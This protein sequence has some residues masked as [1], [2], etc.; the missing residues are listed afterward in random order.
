MANLYNRQLSHW[1]TW[2]W[3]TVIII[4]DTRR[5]HLKPALHLLWST[6]VWITCVWLC[7][8]MVLL[9]K[10]KY[11]HNLVHLMPKAL[12]FWIR[13]LKHSTWHHCGDC[14]VSLS[15]RT[16]SMEWGQRIFE[17]QPTHCYILE[18]TAY[19]ES[20]FVFYKLHASISHTHTPAHIMIIIIRAYT[21][22]YHTTH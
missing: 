15:V 13:Y 21:P 12:L 16:T 20:M 8:G 11:A 4:I 14:L 19:L 1:F 7:M 17:Q 18:V 9:I 22:T 3:T 5:C 2:Q 10:D 6:E